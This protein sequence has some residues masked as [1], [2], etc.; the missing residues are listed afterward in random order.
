MSSGGPERDATTPVAKS[1][2]ELRD[3]LMDAISELC[4]NADFRFGSDS[5]RAKR[6]AWAAL[7]VLMARLEAAPDA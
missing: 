3:D 5:D 6:E 2:D 1:N 4:G 7:D